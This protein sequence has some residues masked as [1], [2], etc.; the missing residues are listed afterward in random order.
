MGAYSF[1]EFGHVHTLDGK[2]LTGVTT[3]LGVIAKPALIQW[4]ANQV[5]EHIKT[6]CPKVEPC[7][8][9][10]HDY[11]EVTVD[12]LEDARTAH[13]KKKETAGEQGTAIHAEIEKLITVALAGDGTIGSHYKRDDHPKQVVKFI[14]WAAENKVKF[15]A[16]EQNLYS[17]EWWVGGIADIVCEIDGKR[18]IG[19]IKT[20]SGIYPEHFIQCSAYAE[21]ACEMGL[22]DKFDGVIIL[23]LKKTGGFETRQFL[24][25]EQGAKVFESAVNIYRFKESVK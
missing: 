5:C 3:I 16:S 10:D 4:A 9:S 13:C 24:D 17:R 1:D 25:V 18:Y 22:Y 8:A 15:L 19:D 6:N 12:D 7:D 20:S 23:N 11:Y 2:P 14:D 21:M